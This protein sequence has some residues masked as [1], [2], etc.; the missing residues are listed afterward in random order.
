MEIK[1]LQKAG[2]RDKFDIYPY[3]NLIPRKLKNFLWLRLDI[4]AV[5]AMLLRGKPGKSW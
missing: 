1:V 5:S 2:I 3:I 4:Q